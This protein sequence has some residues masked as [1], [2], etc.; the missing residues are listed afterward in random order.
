MSELSFLHTDSYNETDLQSAIQR[1]F[2]LLNI[3]IAPDAR[4]VIKPNLI[5]R[6]GPERAA[7]THPAIVEAVVRQL[8]AMG[9]RDI[10]IAD[11]PGGL[12]TPQLLA[13]AYAATGME[14]V[15]KQYGVKLNT[16]VGSRELRG[17][18]AALCRTFDIIDPVADAD[19]VINLCK[20]K[21]HCMTMLSCGVKNLFGCI[22][23]LLKPQLH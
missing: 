15:A 3:Q 8:Q 5:M 13:A 12:Y 23:G 19:C 7:T 17:A 2:E 10:T 1:H 18:D 20:L 21:T 22:P 9:V 6:C 11:S 14:T 16:T 4:V